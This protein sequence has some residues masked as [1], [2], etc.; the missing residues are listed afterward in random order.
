VLRCNIDGKLLGAA[1]IERRQY[2]M[3]LTHHLFKESIIPIPSSKMQ[4][5]R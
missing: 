3:G 4:E 1:N 2:I 5:E